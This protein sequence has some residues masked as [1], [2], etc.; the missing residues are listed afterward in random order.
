MNPDKLLFRWIRSRKRDLD[1]YVNTS[2]L[3]TAQHF[4]GNRSEEIAYR[5][6]EEVVAASSAPATRR[7]VSLRCTR[8]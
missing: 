1:R 2:R 6:V 8:S 7:V 5:V 3:R 4:H